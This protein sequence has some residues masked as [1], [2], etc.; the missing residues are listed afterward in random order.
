MATG[1]AM[2]LRIT[3][4]FWPSPV[5]VIRQQS[6]GLHLDFGRITETIVILFQMCVKENVGEA[7][8]FWSSRHQWPIPNETV[9]T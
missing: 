1:R 4:G 7:D 3:A 2:R 8:T 5:I 9:L 6:S